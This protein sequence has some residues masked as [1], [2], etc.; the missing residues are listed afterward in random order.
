M[1]MLLHLSGQV[2]MG[3]FSGMGVLVIDEGFDL[4]LHYVNLFSAMIPA[5]LEP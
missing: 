3:L 2:R 1:S 5:L 4:L